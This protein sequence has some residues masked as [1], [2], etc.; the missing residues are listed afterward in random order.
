AP[1][2]HLPSFPT[3]RSSDLLRR[4]SMLAHQLDA[5][6]RIVDRNLVAHRRERRADKCGELRL[7]GCAVAIAQDELRAFAARIVR[8][9]V[10]DR[11]S[12][13][14]TSELQSLAYLVC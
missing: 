5:L 2:S 3:R 13:E 14:H 7:A 9:H 10:A 12:E 6:V 11:R 1:L 8:H 4:P